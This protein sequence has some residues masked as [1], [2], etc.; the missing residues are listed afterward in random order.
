MVACINFITLSVGRSIKRAKEVGIRKVV[1]AERSQLIFQ[2]IGE[3]II[4]TL[5]ALLV[6]LALAVIALPLFNDLSGK[7][8]EVKPDGFI[9]TIAFLL[10]VIIGLVAGSYPS[11]VL[12]NFKPIAILKGKLQTGGSKQSLRK[13]LVG[14][15]LVLSIFLVSSTLD[16]IE[17]NWR[18]FNLMFLVVVV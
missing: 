12:S 9:F 17:N 3:A 16:S 13:A 2:F 4:I 10:V 7:A 1:G 14:V 5:T 18:L 6:G 15:Q 8:L 11:F